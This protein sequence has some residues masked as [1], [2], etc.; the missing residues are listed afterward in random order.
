[1]RIINSLKSP[2]SNYHFLEKFNKITYL[3]LLILSI[4]LVNYYYFKDFRKWN[5]EKKRGEESSNELMNGWMGEWIGRM[6][7]WIC[8]WVNGIWWMN[9]RGA[10]MDWLNR[11][12]Q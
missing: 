12:E 8:G 7:E 10:W 2:P 9:R 11:N 5:I 6:D 4:K 3:K 1:M